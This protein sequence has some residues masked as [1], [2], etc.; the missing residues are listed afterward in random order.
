MIAA[1][2]VLAGA[3][4]CSTLRV[5]YDNADTLLLYTFDSYLDLD[6]AQT[7]FLRQRVKAVLAWHRATQL[8]DYAAQ[9]AA[10]QARIGAGNLA[11]AEVLGY[12][13]LF[14][15]RLAAIGA[16]AA[17]DFAQLGATL[18][19]AQ[20]D[21]LRAKL[22]QDADK[23]RHRVQRYAGAGGLDERVAAYVERAEPWFGSFGREQL[24]L[25][26]A[27]LAARP[28]AQARWADEVEQRGRDLIR[29]LERQ[30]DENPDPALAAEWMRDYF[31][32]L[33][34]PEDERRRSWLEENRRD[35]AALIA[36]LIN[37]ATPKQLNHLARR[38][39][40]YA[41][42]FAALA[43]EGARAGEG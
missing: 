15:A 11:G 24:D 12:I 17:P 28:G 26:R 4:A 1:L 3:T 41:D 43:A 9:L 27:S 29:L 37:A 5:G 34:T 20:I 25:I 32:H 19:P 38:L 8:R 7:A 31:L 23:A 39:A 10:I 42:D 30:R 21:R 35:N 40:Q 33:S 22:A 6:D 36:Q 18:Q 14:D 2:A 13:D 16:Q